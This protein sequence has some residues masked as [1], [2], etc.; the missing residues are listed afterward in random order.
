[1][2]IGYAALFP[3]LGAF[4]VILAAR[5]KS[6]VTG[7]VVFQKIGAWSY[8]IYLWHWPLV[9]GIYYYTLNDI[10]IF[11]GIAL[12][13]LLGFISNRYIEKIR[14][15]NGFYSARAYLKCKPLYIML[16][17]SILSLSVIANKGDNYWVNNLDSTGY[18]TYSLLFNRD[19]ENDDWG[20]S[21]EGVQ[22]F[23]KCNFNSLSLTDEIEVRLKQC[24]LTS[25]PEVL[26][27]GDSHSKDLFGM[28]SSAFEND[29]IVGI[30]NTQG[31][32]PHTEKKDCQEH[33]LKIKNF[34]INNSHIFEHVIYEQAGF[35]LLLDENNN[36]GT[37]EM[38]NKLAL[39]VKVENIKINEAYVNQVTS[40]LTQISEAI[41]VTWFGPRIEPH[42]S[43]QQVLSRGCDYKF[44][45]RDGH[46]IV[47]NNLDKYILAA[48][49][50]RKNLKFLSQNKL[51]DYNF[52]EDFMTCES[53]F[54]TDGD[55]LSSTGEKFFGERLPDDFLGF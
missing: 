44:S 11:L 38:F 32:R 30:T 14:F 28:V 22:N 34:L 43:P 15:K 18:K 39:T 7:N 40:Y 29:F 20:V 35:Y 42:F 17:I 54:W 55:H 23:S 21:S 9:V 5:D 19:K 16:F 6:F 37:R 45:L 2:A 24:A 50:K 31:C 36:K 53:I 47:F 46:K 10:Y 8:S 27:I 33:Y 25:N 12:S 48:A 49:S 13:V 3:V 1:M 52:Q 51:I 41:P 4:F 26:I